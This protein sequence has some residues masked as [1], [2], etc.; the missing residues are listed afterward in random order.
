MAW[1]NR[2]CIRLKLLFSIILF[3]YRPKKMNVGLRAIELLQEKDKVG[4][5]FYF[6]VNGVPVFMKGANYIPPDSF[7][8]RTSDSVYKSIVKNAKDSNMNML[9]VWGGGVYAD[10]AFYDECDKNGILVWQDFM[11]ACAMYSA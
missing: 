6:K 4:K 5:S 2:S 10:D 7:L 3:R 11:F 8:P 9:R 1:E